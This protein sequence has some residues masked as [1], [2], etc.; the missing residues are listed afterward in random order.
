MSAGSTASPG[1]KGKEDIIKALK[2]DAQTAKTIRNNETEQKYGQHVAHVYGQ[3][4]ETW[5][6]AIEDVLFNGTIKRT[7]REAH[8]TQL[9]QVDVI[10]SDYERVE[11]GM[12]KCSTW[13][14]GHDEPNEI[15]AAFPEPDEVLEDVLAL[16]RWVNDIKERRKKAP[17]FKVLAVGTD[18]PTPAPVV[19]LAL[20]RDGKP[21][22]PVPSA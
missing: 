10:P 21:L 16:D 6:R 22:Q 7:A 15:N 14:N 13:F 4:R 19:D 12:K 20:V 1:N 8:T 2:N 9:K 17:A 5:E 11:A 3:L 18:L